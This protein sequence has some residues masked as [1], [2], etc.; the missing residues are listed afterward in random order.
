MVPCWARAKGV[1]A[2]LRGYA[3][4]HERAPLK[5]CGMAL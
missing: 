4:A 2:P 1:M 5:E 3:R